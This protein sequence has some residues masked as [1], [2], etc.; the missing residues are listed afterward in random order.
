MN[1]HFSVLLH[2]FVLV[3]MLYFKLA[4]RTFVDGY[5]FTSLRWRMSG[6]CVSYLGQMNVTVFL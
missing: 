2:S 6:Q 4:L 1:A 3:I 5:M